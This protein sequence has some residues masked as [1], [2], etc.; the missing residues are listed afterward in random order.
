[1]ED[2]Q[3][4]DRLY[5]LSRLAGLNL[6][7]QIESNTLSEIIQ[8]NSDAE[9]LPALIMTTADYS[10]VSTAAVNAA[11]CPTVQV[12]ELRFNQ[13]VDGV[14]SMIGA[15][16]CRLQYNELTFPG[17]NVV[18]GGS[19]SLTKGD[20]IQAGSGDDT[21][22]GNE[23]NDLVNA[24]DGNNQIYGGN[25]NDVLIDRGNS[26]SIGVLNGGDGNDVLLPGNGLKGNNPGLGDDVVIAGVAPAVALMGL[27]NDKFLGNDT[28][29]DTATGDDGSDWLEGHGGLD[30]LTGDAAAVFGIDTV[31]FGSDYLWG[32]S[33]NDVL[34]GGGASDILGEGDGG[35]GSDTMTGGFGWDWVT[36]QGSTTA[37]S[38][39][40]LCGNAVPLTP[41][42]GIGVVQCPAGFVDAFIDPIEGMVGGPHDDYM[43]GDDALTY[44]ATV[45]I[46]NSSNDL[47]SQDFWMLNES[48]NAVA[49]GLATVLGI[50]QPATNNTTV[51]TPAQTG[52]IMLAG[53]GSDELMGGGGNDFIYGDGT[54]TV[55]LRVKV[56][57]ANGGG[58]AYVQSMNDLVGTPAKSVRDM[59]I[60]QSLD[61][62]DL[63]PVTSY[64]RGTPALGEVDTA[65]YS[66]GFADYSYVTNADG[67]VTVTQ[68]TAA[69]GGG[70]GAGG[71]KSDDSDRLFGIEQLK[72]LNLA[73]PGALP[74]TASIANGFVPSAPNAVSAVSAGITSAQVTW[75]VPTYPNAVFAGPITTYTVAATSKAPG[76]GLTLTGT[77]AGNGTRIRYNVNNPAGAT[78]IVAGDIVT[79]TGFVNGELNLTNAVVNAATTARVDILSTSTATE[80]LPVGG[81]RIVKAQVVNTAN[82]ATL[83]AT[84]AGLTQGVAY[85][86]AVRANTTVARAPL[87]GVFST[88]VAV[89][90]AA[91]LPSQPLNVVATNAGPTSA[92]ISWNAPSIA[93]DASLLKYQ[94][95]LTDTSVTPFVVLSDV[96]ASTNTVRS[97][98]VNNQLTQ[99][100]VYSVT[101]SAVNSLGAGATS[102]PVTVTPDFLTNPTPAQNLVLSTAGSAQV[103]VSWDASVYEGRNANPALMT[104][105]ATATRAGQTVS[106]SATAANTKC[107]LVGLTNGSTYTVSVVA[108][109]NLGSSSTA[110]TGTI[111][112]S[113]ATIPGLPTGLAIGVPTNTTLP[114]N[115]VAPLVNGNA[116][117]TGYEV[118]AYT[119]ATGT[120]ATGLQPAGT[121]TS[122]APV[123]NCDVTGLKPGTA[124]WVSV[125][126]QNST[127][128]VSSEPAT[129]TVTQFTTG[130]SVTSSTITSSSGA[131]QL[132]AN[133]VSTSTITVQLKNSAGTNL[134]ASN[135]TVVLSKTGSGTLSN[136]VESAPGTWTATYTTTAGGAITPVAISGTFD[137]AA[138][139]STATVN[140]T[141][142]TPSIATSTLALTSDSLPANG[143]TTAGFV[144]ITV[145]DASGV[146]IAGQ[147]N[148]PTFTVTAGGGSVGTPTFSGAGVWTAPFTSPLTTSTGNVSTPTATIV[149]TLPGS[150]ALTSRNVTN[151]VQ[152]VSLAD[153][154]VLACPVL[155]PGTCTS[156]VTLESDGVSTA[157]IQV[158]LKDATGVNLVW[159]GVQNP[160]TTNPLT[161]V[162]DQGTVTSV[163]YPAATNPVAAKGLWTATYTSAAGYLPG[164]LPGVNINLAT[165]YNTQQLTNANNVVVTL[166]DPVVAAGNT[167]L[168]AGTSG[169]TPTPFDVGTG[170][171][172]PVKIMLRN[173]NNVSMGIDLSA[174]LAL[175][176]AS[177]SFSSIQHNDGTIEPLVMDDVTYP[178]DYYTANYTPSVKVSGRVHVRVDFDS[179]EMPEIGEVDVI[180]SNLVDVSTSV[181]SVSDSSLEALGANYS[182]VT[183]Q[184][185]NGANAD[186]SCN[187]VKDTMTLQFTSNFAGRISG[188]ACDPATGMWTARFTPT[189]D[190]AGSAVIS[191][192]IT[193]KPASGPATFTQ[194]AVIDT[195]TISVIGTQA[196]VNQSQMS[197]LGASELLG[198]GTSQTTIALQLRDS[199]NRRLGKSGGTVQ[200]LSSMG[201]ISDA[202]YD[203][204]NDV[205]IATFT[206]PNNIAGNAVISALV[207]SAGVV[208]TLNVK[209]TAVPQVTANVASSQLGLVAPA[210]AQKN[211]Y[212]SVKVTFPSKFKSAKSTITIR[213]SAGKKVASSSSTQKKKANATLKVKIPKKLT[214]GSYV[215]TVTVKV[216]S[217]TYTS[218]QT[219]VQVK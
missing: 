6:G 56:P 37:A 135:G 192:N 137:G 27:G 205:W 28:G 210:V 200:F 76:A 89:T 158:Q 189:K 217:I 108:T 13:L 182:T 179:M 23:G 144:T 41:V 181:I 50:A 64:D 219:T 51:V 49:N 130:A 14:A 124:Y 177:G 140:L 17:K 145:R 35:A 102:T 173:T 45:G 131:T 120:L 155:T 80:A 188:E 5:Y 57:A 178:G 75:S 79:I 209:I 125:L 34:D 12:H 10:V 199:L 159:S 20:N 117:I 176:S 59:L 26:S 107:T 143:A 68:V 55:E 29:N 19:N 44:A 160:V 72:F 9:N 81:A 180:G 22:R 66:L 54:Q 166:I 163:S 126:T 202:S 8:R 212:Y 91:V 118:R 11:D 82:A 18:Y 58:F 30:G 190:T 67:S 100:H 65:V 110:V 218:S 162:A 61:P 31:K 32:G 47:T 197:N 196:N 92:S 134:T 21:V 191:A 52:N 101:V 119:V 194:L 73:T 129:R 216:G 2:L 109:N 112:P 69:A 71:V 87:G 139:T 95:D 38:Y 156:A 1:M 62:K 215:V 138:I 141:N 24:G 98:S 116:P 208:S 198:N 186:I 157:P 42:G 15:L 70:G 7:L 94:V 86:V 193:E 211:K 60:D 127:P 53:P 170:G 4:G 43:R 183:L 207:N 105:R 77:T 152:A 90:P 48:N 161:F 142:Q 187:T 203:A 185:K 3:A 16:N 39:D 123:T 195:K 169:T 103:L 97:C 171:F 96:C 83:S 115:W 214:P 88:N 150:G 78:Q 122:I 84:F 74:T 93:G 201:T 63:V 165:S 113:T 174:R 151:T 128:L 213:N 167:I 85:D 114:V 168:V 25:G 153:S 164:P 206:S 175:T 46:A 172:V 204:V 111:I 99:L 146:I 106:C 36:A 33:A 104:Y 133:G 148:T 136:V 147:G 121:C 132:L 154:T 40:G 184:L 149:A